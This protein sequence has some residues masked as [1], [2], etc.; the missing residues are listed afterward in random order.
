MRGQLAHLSRDYEAARALLSV[1]ARFTG[2]SD[3]HTR[4]L[5]RIEESRMSRILIAT[6]PLTGHVLPGLGIAR[7]LA[8]RGHDVFWYTGKRHRHAVERAGARF[9]PMRAARDFDDGN[10]DGE[11]PGRAAHRGFFQFRFDL[12]RLFVDS[13]PGQ[14]ADLAFYAR[15]YSFDTMVNDIGFCGLPLF[16]E[17]EQLRYASFGISAL[18]FPSIDAAPFGLGLAPSQTTL[19]RIRNRMLQAFMDHVAFRE[20]NLQYAALR[21]RVGL[22]AR[23]NGSLTADS[24]GPY[25]YLQASV[26]GFEYPRSDL[27]PQ[28]EFT[29]PFLPERAEFTPP[30]WWADL[31]GGLPIVHVTQGTAATHSEQLLVPTLEAL[32]HEPVLV[33]ATT[34]GKPVESLR[35]ANIPKN[36]RVAPFIPYAELMPR[37]DLMITNGGYGGVQIALAHGVPLIAAGDTED[38]PEIARRIEWSGVGIDLRTSRP[39]PTKIRAAVHALMRDSSYRQHAKRLQTEIARH[40]APAFA[41]R[42]IERLLAA[43]ARR[44]L[45]EMSFSEAPS[46]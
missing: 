33:V 5:P 23:R 35:I 14:L 1:F 16:A 28:V 29:G 6:L 4:A 45:D 3:A 31:D 12:Q 7:A 34:G 36:A 22:P 20:V 41:V 17:R 38:K 18:A 25:V 42:A 46:E 39:S 8:Q 26:P 40:D 13:I 30:S 44:R 32:R 11:F 21:T 19:G 9:L 2:A 43:P 37:T 27:P 10:L 24:L 15:A